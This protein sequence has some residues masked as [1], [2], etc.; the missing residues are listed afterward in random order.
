[1]LGYIRDMHIHGGW[2]FGLGL[3]SASHSIWNQL[4]ANIKNV[5]YII[6]FKNFGLFLR[7]AEWRIKNKNKKIKKKISEFFEE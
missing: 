4:K 5:Y 1:M 2:D 6:P 7:E 3:N